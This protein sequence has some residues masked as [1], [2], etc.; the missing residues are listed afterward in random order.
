MGNVLIVSGDRPVVTPVAKFVRSAGYESAVTERGDNGCEMARRLRFDAIIVDDLLAGCVSGARVCRE[1]RSHSSSLGIIFLYNVECPDQALEAF[2]MG[3]DDCIGKLPSEAEFCARLTALV[4]RSSLNMGKR[5]VLNS[6]E[7]EPLG[8]TVTVQGSRVELT[9]TQ[10]RLL[11]YI[12]RNIG[13]PI[14]PSEF[15]QSIFRSEQ[16]VDSSKLRVHIF[17]LRRRLGSVGLLIESVRG[18]GYGIG[19]G[20][21]V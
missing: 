4:R 10:Y 11:D 12:L 13:R 20:Q 5:V 14:S 16:T 9:P 19:L 6:I 15:K 3:A 8:R 2:S 18:K 17:E 21:A 1:L 7:I